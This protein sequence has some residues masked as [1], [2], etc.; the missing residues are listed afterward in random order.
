MHIHENALQPKKPMICVK[1]AAAPGSLGLSGS[2]AADTQG[3]KSRGRLSAGRL[4]RATSGTAARRLPWKMAVAVQL[5]WL[6]TRANVAVRIWITVVFTASSVAPDT[7]QANTAAVA[8]ARDHRAV[9][10]ARAMVLMAGR[11]E[12]RWGRTGEAGW[13]A[14]I[15]LFFL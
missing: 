11:R 3:S 4:Y 2:T 14:K 1:D 7:A 13:W 8:A 5:D 9:R 12:D 6:I 15:K 10:V